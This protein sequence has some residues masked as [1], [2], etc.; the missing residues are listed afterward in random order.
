MKIIVTHPFSDGASR[1]WIKGRRYEVDDKTGEGFIAAGYARAAYTDLV[2]DLAEAGAGLMVTA[3]TDP[4]LVA[5]ARKAKLPT[6]KPRGKKKD[7][8]PPE[9]PAGS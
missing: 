2:A 1:V 7:E 8:E 6:H 4:H 3:D 9:E 5:E